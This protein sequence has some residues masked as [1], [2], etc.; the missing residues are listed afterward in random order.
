MHLDRR[1]QDRARPAYAVSRRP[2]LGAYLKTATCPHL[3]PIPALLSYV[4]PLTS[5]LSSR[6]PGVFG[7][8]GVWVRRKLLELRDE[9]RVAGVTHR[10]AQ[11]PKPATVLGSLD[12]RVAQEVL[13]TTGRQRLGRWLALRKAA[14][15]GH[16]LL[17]RAGQG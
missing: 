7:D 1:R 2:S 15:R 13:L 6:P 3:Y 4:S 9:A 14:R 10:H 16:L 8:D 5:A 12:G 11:V 17:A